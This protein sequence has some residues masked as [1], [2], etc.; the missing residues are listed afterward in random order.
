MS[1]AVRVGV[2]GVVVAEVDRNGRGSRSAG[3]RTSARARGC[4]SEVVWMRARQGTRLAAARQLLA[5]PA[6]P[7][8]WDL[9][10][11]CGRGRAHS[12]HGCGRH[13]DSAQVREVGGRQTPGGFRAERGAL[14]AAHRG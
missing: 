7:R 3:S 10:G 11:R 5:R 8:D 6:P 9:R 2:R 13:G 12:C 1:A 14:R 4:V